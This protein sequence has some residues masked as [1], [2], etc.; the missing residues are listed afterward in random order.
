MPLLSA[1]F[2]QGLVDELEHARGQRTHASLSRPNSMNRYGAKM[3]EIGFGPWIDGIMQR[4]VPVLSA[5]MFPDWG[6]TSISSEHTFT[7]SYRYDCLRRM[8]G[9][10]KL[11]HVMCVAEWTKTEL[12]TATS[13]SL[14]SPLT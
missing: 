14:P 1:S 11:R 6:G 2:C 12:W 5:M 8:S 9:Q 4:V 7:V 3:R 13:T 10:C